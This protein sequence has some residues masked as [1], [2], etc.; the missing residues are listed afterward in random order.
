MCP[1]ANNRP[2]LFRQRLVLAK[3]YDGS[4]PVKNIIDHEIKQR[5]A[6]WMRS[7]SGRFSPV[8]RN[9]FAAGPSTNRLP[10]L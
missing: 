10:G 5:Y 9:S 1:A 2:K 8:S 6:A 4:T 7:G 3:Q